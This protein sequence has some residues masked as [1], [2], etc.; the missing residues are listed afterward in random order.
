M[1]FTSFDKTIAGGVFAAATAVLGAVPFQHHPPAWSIV[2]AAVLT[3]LS[4]FFV[5]NKT[6]DSE[7]NLNNDSGMVDIPPPVEP[8]RSA[9]IF[10]GGQIPA[11]PET[12]TAKYQPLVPPVSSDQPNEPTT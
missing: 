12:N 1:A 6:S 5:P 11:P 10:T 2:A 8:P 9:K 3:P 7:S 4:V